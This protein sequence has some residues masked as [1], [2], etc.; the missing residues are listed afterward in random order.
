MDMDLGV[1]LCGEFSDFPI[2]LTTKLSRIPVGY[3]PSEKGGS[4]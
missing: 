4:P 3:Y 2:S 1:K